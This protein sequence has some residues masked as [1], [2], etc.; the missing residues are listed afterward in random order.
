MIRLFIEDN[1][2]DVDQGFSNQITY[3]I[4]D[5]QNLDSKATAFSKTIVLPGTANNNR[6][7]GNIFEFG[8][9]NFTVDG[10]ANVGYNFNASRSAKMKMEYNGV[11]V[12]KGTLRLLE[13]VIDEGLIEY[14]IALFGEL[15]GFF[16]IGRAHV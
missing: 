1:E 8:S 5:L 9:A 16:E 14:E 3:A 12:I 11:Q 15:G 7:L 10:S 13:I 4:D 6:L 2:L